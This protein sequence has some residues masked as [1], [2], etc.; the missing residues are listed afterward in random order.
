MPPRDPR[1]YLN[2]TVWLQNKN[3][4]EQYMNLFF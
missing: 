1:K 3:V 4:N 2:T